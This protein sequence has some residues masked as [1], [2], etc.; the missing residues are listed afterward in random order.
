MIA[1]SLGRAGTTLTKGR[2]NDALYPSATTRN[3]LAEV[4]HSGVASYR[5]SLVMA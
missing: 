1:T 2:H 5:R 4:S 3:R